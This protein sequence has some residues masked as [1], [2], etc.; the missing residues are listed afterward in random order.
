MLESVLEI[1]PLDRNLDGLTRRLGGEDEN[2]ALPTI[3]GGG[4]WNKSQNA[5]YGAAKTEDLID[6]RLRS[7][8]WRYLGWETPFVI[9]PR[10][11]GRV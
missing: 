10:Q 3:R 6:E 1:F 9:Y 7:G 8:L 2:P 11:I 4:D 5:G